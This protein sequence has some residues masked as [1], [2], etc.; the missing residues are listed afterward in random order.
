ALN[1][2][3]LG[4][5]TTGPS[6][7]AATRVGQLSWSSRRARRTGLTGARRGIPSGPAR[8]GLTACLALRASSQHA[9]EDRDDRGQ[10]GERNP[11]QGVDPAEEDAA[12][13]DER[14]SER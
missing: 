7:T 3:Q 11:D 14:Q 13:K 8:V 4:H 5:R 9:V 10:D 6:L 12:R 2:R 1:V